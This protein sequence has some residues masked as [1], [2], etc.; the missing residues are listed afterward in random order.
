MSSITLKMF[1]LGEIA[2]QFRLSLRLYSDPRDPLKTE[3]K[4]EKDNVS[5][6]QCFVSL[7]RDVFT[8][9]SDFVIFIIYKIN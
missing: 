4:E 7:A 8:P 2:G 5:N 1:R 6:R 9:I 3:E